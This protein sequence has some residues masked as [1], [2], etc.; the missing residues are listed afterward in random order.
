MGCG[1]IELA[2][3]LVR[4]AEA[5]TRAS[6]AS[7]ASRSACG[8]TAAGQAEAGIAFVP[9]SR[10]ACCSP[11]SR[12]TR[13]SRSPSWSRSRSSGSSPTRERA[14]AERHIKALSIR[15][16]DA[17][18]AARHA[19][20][21]QPAEG[22][23]GHWLT[24]LPQGADPLRADHAA[25]MSAPRKTWCAS[26]ESL[27]DQGVGIIVLSTEPETVLSL[28]DR[29]IVMRKG[30]VAQEF[31]DRDHQQ[32][33]AA[34]RRLGTDRPM[35]DL[36][37]PMT[38]P[39]AISSP[40]HGRQLAARPAAQYRALPDAAVPRRCSSPSPARPSRRSATSGTSC[41]RSR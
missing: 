23:A 21:R 20:G 7:A 38:A 13:T 16:P 28:A 39:A 15:A 29:I 11:T 18:R 12:S 32:G 1:Q 14:I 37:R 41:S 40:R 24:H 34:G 36:D 4:Q 25:W 10:R 27:R 35:N 30:Q 31:A 17:E 6:C 26:C 9:E 3:T 5:A 8:N 33:P 2:R 19:L 22:G